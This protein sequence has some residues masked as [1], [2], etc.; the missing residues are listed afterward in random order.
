[1]TREYVHLQSLAFALLDFWEQSDWRKAN[2][3]HMSPSA[4]GQS[5]RD[6]SR[7]AK[8]ASDIAYARNILKG[9]PTPFKNTGIEP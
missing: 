4:L 9:I 2:M 3:H 6:L 8:L 1:M 5:I 7:A